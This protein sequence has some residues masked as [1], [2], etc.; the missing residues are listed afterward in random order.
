MS[1]G[2]SPS[3]PRV[4][5]PD[6]PERQGERRGYN[7]V[8]LNLER[9]AA[10]NPVRKNEKEVSGF[11]THIYLAELNGSDSVAVKID[12]PG[13]GWITMEEGD[14][15]SREFT[16]FFVRS[17]S[18]FGDA[19]N[20][21]RSLGGPCEA[22]FYV[23]VG[24]MILRAP[25][26]YGFRSGFFTV[27]GVATTTGV[28]AFGGF[29]TQYAALFPKGLPAY[30]KYG[31]TLLVR[32]RSAVDNLYIYMGTVGSFASGGGVYP[33]ETTSI[34]IPPGVTLPM[35]IENRLANLRHPDGANR[36]NTLI[37]AR[38]TAGANVAFTVTP[39]RMVFDFSD[40]ESIPPG[41]GVI[42]LDQ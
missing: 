9:D 15:V 38:S 19:A 36:A 1:E 34:E 33:D 22:T 16:R 20:S 25:K 11:G 24:P 28:D 17:N 12:V 29:A 35:L 27:G 23:S 8:Q 26:K 32:N 14:I 5:T 6:Q 10:G 7:V 40:P 2:R 42:G 18:R 13:A 39:S 31:G 3:L 37:A 21:F 41:S 30:L 4:R